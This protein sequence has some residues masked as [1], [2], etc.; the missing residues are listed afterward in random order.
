MTRIRLLKFMAASPE[1]QARQDLRRARKV[2][3]STTGADYVS[4]DRA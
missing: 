1:K 2:V 4:I 3:V